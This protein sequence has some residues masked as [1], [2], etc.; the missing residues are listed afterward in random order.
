M[1]HFP[2]HKLRI[3]PTSEHLPPDWSLL[4][5]TFFFT[6]PFLLKWRVEWVTDSSRE[7]LNAEDAL[8]QS[9]EKGGIL[10]PDSEVPATTESIL[11]RFEV[12]IAGPGMEEAVVLTIGESPCDLAGVWDRLPSGIIRYDIVAL[13]GA[14]QE[15]GFSNLHHF[16]KN[17]HPVHD[18]ELPELLLA[19][20]ARTETVEWPEVTGAM[21]RHIRPFVIRPG[22][23]DADI[24][25]RTVR[26]R[27]QIA[28]TGGCE[29]IESNE[30]NLDTQPIWDRVAVGPCLL[31]IQ[32]LDQSGDTIGLSCEFTFKKGAGHVSPGIPN[33]KLEKLDE[34]FRRIAQYLATARS[35]KARKPDLPI[36]FWHSSVDEWGNVS[37]SSFPSQFE[38]G[39]EA[40]RLCRAWAE[41]NGDDELAATAQ[42]EEHRMVEWVL[43]H[44]LPEG[45]ALAGLPATTLTRGGIGGHVEGESISL[46]GVATIA[47]TFI[48]MHGDTGDGKVLEAARTAANLLLQFQNDD[49]SW[50]WRVKGKTGE[51]DHG[52]QY[53]SQVIEIVRL[54][55]MLD[56][57]DP[58]SQYR[59]AAD[60]GLRW[61]LD[62]P[63][64][65]HRW[66]GYYIDDP[67]G[68]PMYSSVSHLDAV[69]T[70]RFLVDHREEDSAYLPIA[71]EIESWVENHFVIYG[72]ETHW[73]NSSIVSTEPVTPAVIEKPFYQRTVTGHTANW[74]GLLLDLHCATGEEPYLQK[75]E[76][77]CAAIR[78]AVLPRGAVIPESPD[79]LLH[80]RPNGE[81][82][83]FWNAW[84]VMK[85]LLEMERELFREEGY[86]SNG[87]SSSRLD[88]SH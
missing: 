86:T 6:Q 12:R 67:G 19:S 77:A 51:P 79:R 20:G 27:G 43:S 4:S 24:R 10:H 13:D 11:Y 39:I 73:G 34:T 78:T 81:S 62:N 18:L 22:I 7:I 37:G 42:G 35:P 57:L 8:R 82:L 84:S 68:M 72:R 65:T 70:A 26:W 52:A 25:Q 45:W 75:A 76:A 54:Y 49:G 71:R 9:A 1:I 48:W 15:L 46:P 30:P 50:P 44:R 87:P 14:G 17:A 56:D 33:P 5:E 83:W 32:A 63:V 58:Q 64:R 55:R 2:L 88:R 41:R 53:T 28:H 47:R 29:S 38:V 80:R 85:G 61:I 74:M 59:A 60:S 36:Y 21:L 16:I 23:K 40:W 3:F 69:W 66:E 31:R